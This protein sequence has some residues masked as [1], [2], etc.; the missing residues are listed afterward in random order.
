MLAVIC[1]L[2]G[3]AAMVAA[4]YVHYHLIFDP[5]YASF[6]DINTTVNC[7]QVYLSRY[8]TVN[9]VPVAI[10]GVIFFAG[11]LLLLLAGSVG[12]QVMRENVPG[13]LFALSTAGLAVVLYLHCRAQ[14]VLR[15]VS[16]LR[17]R[18][19]RVVP[20][21]RRC[22]FLSHDDITPTSRHR[23]ASLDFEP[24]RHCRH[25]AVLRR[26]RVSRGVLPA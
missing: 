21:V 15:L 18:G 2:A 26:R 4:A 25:R 13:Y 16:D 20:G 22:H 12:P 14:G 6:C 9:G 3:L 23:S 19:G 7:T 24:D 1:A 11:V 17:R 5:R 8:S 10:Y